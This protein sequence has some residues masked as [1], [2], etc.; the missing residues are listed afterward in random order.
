MFIENEQRCPEIT[1]LQVNQ[2]ISKYFYT[3]HILDNEFCD[4]VIL[5]FRVANTAGSGVGDFADVAYWIL[6][7]RHSSQ[8]KRE[9]RLN[10]HQVNKHLDNIATK[11][12][13][14]KPS[15]ERFVL[16]YL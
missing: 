3:V 16:L 5:R 4:I 9:N 15:N 2:S 14:H 7:A 12:A 8:Q 6:H 11:H 1:E 10:I 13:E